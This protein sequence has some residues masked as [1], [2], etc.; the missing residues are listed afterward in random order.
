MYNAFGRTLDPAQL[1]L[2]EVIIIL[3]LMCARL[4]GAAYLFQAVFINLPTCLL[5]IR[6]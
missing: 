5:N 6:T 2:V 4:T 3:E 1:Q